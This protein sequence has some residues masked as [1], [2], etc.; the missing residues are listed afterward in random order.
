[1]EIYGP[2]VLDGTRR[3]VSEKDD[4]M[5]RKKEAEVREEKEETGEPEKKRRGIVLCDKVE[6]ISTNGELTQGVLAQGEKEA[7]KEKVSIDWLIGLLFSWLI[8]KIIE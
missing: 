1:M 8:V 2:L 5:K 3:V 6:E 7:N 4:E